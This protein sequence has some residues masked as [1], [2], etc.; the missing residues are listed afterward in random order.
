MHWILCLLG[1]HVRSR[2][3][4][5]EEDGHIVSVC[6]HCGRPMVRLGYNDWRVSR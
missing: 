2:G 6:R 5:H 1:F 4:A 3:K